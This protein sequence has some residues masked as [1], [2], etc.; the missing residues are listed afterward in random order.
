MIYIKQQWQQ[1]LR[2]QQQKSSNI[3]TI[4]ARHSEGWA[5]NVQ[6]VTT[7]HTPSCLL[8]PTKYSSI[9]YQI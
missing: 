6:A 5:S 9:T 3:E 1:K 2:Q 8:L 4:S 7:R